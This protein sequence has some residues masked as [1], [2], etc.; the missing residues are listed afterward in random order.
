MFLQHERLTKNIQIVLTK[1][2]LTCNRYSKKTWQ[3]LTS[4]YEAPG[5]RELLGLNNTV[6]EDLR[7]VEVAAKEESIDP[8][9]HDI[10]IETLHTI[11]A[12]HG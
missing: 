4:L 5:T 3:R 1:W 11:Q 2:F 6:A 8:C 9:T 10:T 12:E 7:A